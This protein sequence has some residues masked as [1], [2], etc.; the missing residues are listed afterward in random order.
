[1]LPVLLSIIF[2]LFFTLAI[3]YLVAFFFKE[4]RRHLS[5]RSILLEIAATTL[6]GAPMATMKRR[7][8]RRRTRMV[9]APAPSALPV[10][11]AFCAP[12]GT[13]PVVSSLYF[14]GIA[15]TSTA[16]YSAEGTGDGLLAFDHSRLHCARGLIDGCRYSNGDALAAERRTS[17]EQNSHGLHGSNWI[18]RR[19]RWNR[20]WRQRK[21]RLL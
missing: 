18:R 4:R 10:A 1:M 7:R 21:R 9:A 13:V 16:K 5:Q 19:R 11:V 14:R 15:A 17:A 3:S 6:E 2:S 8:R 20:L 12:V